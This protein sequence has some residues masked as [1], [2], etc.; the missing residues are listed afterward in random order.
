MSRENVEMATRHFGQIVG[1][2]ARFW[3]APRS[4]A[5]AAADGELEGEAAD[6]YLRLHPE[7][8]WTN[9]AGEIYEGLLACA[10]G[11]DALLQAAQA[12]EMRL[13]EVT[14]LGGERVLVVTHS[15]MR[16]QASGVSGEASLFTVVTFH[17]G[18][19]F[20]QTSI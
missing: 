18:M 8:R 2:V 20:E 16:G 13:D 1:E 4:F 19:M 5:D 3:E 17:E 7:V 9:V 11:V 15:T 12:Y 6:V 10:E 14:D